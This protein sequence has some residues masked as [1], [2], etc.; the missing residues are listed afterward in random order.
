MDFDLTEEQQ[1]LRDV[2]KDVFSRDDITKLNEVTSGDPGWRRDVWGQLAEIGILGLGFEPDEAG[3]IEIMVVQ[4]EIGRHLAPEPVAQAAL[5]PGGLIAELGSDAQKE[6]LAAV[7][8]GQTLLAFAHTEPGART[9][10]VA[11]ATQ[12]RDSG[13]GWTLNGRKNPVLAGDSADLVVVSAALPDGGTGL[14]LVDAATVQRTSYRTFD[15]RRGAQLVF[16][17]TPAEPLGDGG[18]AGEHI[19]RAVIRLSSALCAEAVGAMDEALRLTTEYLGS[20]KQFG[21]P[22]STFQTLTQRAADMYVSLELARSMNFYAAMSIADGRYDPLI[23]ARAKLQI[24][25]S[26]RH[27]AQE[28]IQMHGGIGITAEYPVAHYAARLTAIDN[29]LGTADD[30]LRTLTARIGDYEVVSL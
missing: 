18:D 9:P 17:N 28:A 7:A 24:G 13:D 4:T 29:T 3:Q 2:A 12:A 19:A 10:D 15:G 25:R 22:L 27:I 21:V 16:D 11:V 8:G 1:L 26:G 5:V 20:R 30:Q 14:F 6:I 23:A